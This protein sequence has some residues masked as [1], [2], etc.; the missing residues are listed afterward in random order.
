MGDFAM[1]EFDRG[2]FEGVEDTFFIITS[3]RLPFP[4]GK[5]NFSTLSIFPPKTL[6]DLADSSISS[7]T[8]LPLSET[9]NPPTFN[10][11]KQYSLRTVNFATAREVTMLNLSLKFLY[12]HPM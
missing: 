9:K 2:Y 6:I 8:L 1:L 3:D 12:F 5:S 11:G 10:N 7:S 4:S